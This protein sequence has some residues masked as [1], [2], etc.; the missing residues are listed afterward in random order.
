MACYGVTFTLKYL[1]QHF[2]RTKHNPSRYDC[3]IR[4]LEPRVS[5]TVT[6]KTRKDLGNQAQCLLLWAGARV[7]RPP[8]PAPNRPASCRR[9]HS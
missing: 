7:D 5:T 9:H 6:R 4:S 8:P 2:L 1:K 3:M